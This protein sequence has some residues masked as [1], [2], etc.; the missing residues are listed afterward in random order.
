MVALKPLYLALKHV[1]KRTFTIKHPYVM[2]EPAERTVGR[3][4]L[5]TEKCTGCGTCG[6]FCPTSA[7]EMVREEGSK[8][9]G[10]PRYDYGRCCFCSI[11]VLVCPNRALETTG[12]YELSA[13]DKSSLVYPTQLTI[14]APD[15]R[16]GRRSLAPKLHKYGG[17]SHEVVY[18]PHHVRY[19]KI[20]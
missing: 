5:H 6:R 3:Y 1:F 8:G 18:G 7:I 13:Y 20:G 16:R 2:L 12:D 14:T 17:P 19:K 9:L 15:V 11:C 4:L 10:Y